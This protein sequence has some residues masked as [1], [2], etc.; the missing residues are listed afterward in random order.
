MKSAIIGGG[1]IGIAL[2]E[3][4]I[5]AGLCQASDITIT[6]RNTSAL[7][8]LS[9]KGF[10]ITPDNTQAIEKA[11]TIFICVLPQ[12]LDG[13]LEEIRPVVDLDRQLV[14]SVVTGA[15]TQVFQEKLGNTL[16]IIRA[17]PNTA[18]KIG[19]SMTCLSAVNATSDDI[20]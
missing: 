11:T 17:M 20:E 7:A 2:A 6:R 15:H 3:G 10:I 14:V 8:D 9:K 19:E 4:L 16:R 13:V 12:Q 5:R 18:M 1:N